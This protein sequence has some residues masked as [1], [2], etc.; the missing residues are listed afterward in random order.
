MLANC[1]PPPV[2]VTGFSMGSGASTLPARPVVPRSRVLFGSTVLPP[3]RIVSMAQ[4]ITQARP[5]ST[6]A[7]STSRSARC[8]ERRR[9]R[10]RVSFRNS[11]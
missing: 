3:P 2:S 11:R 1:T 4:V 7:A 8:A 10:E 5:S 9:R 6:A